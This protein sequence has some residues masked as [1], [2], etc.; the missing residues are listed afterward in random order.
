MKTLQDRMIELDT[1]KNEIAQRILNEIMA[2][3]ESMP[4]YAEKIGYS[5]LG[6]AI[7]KNV[8][9]NAALLAGILEYSDIDQLL[10][11]IYPLT[12]K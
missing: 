2:G 12:Q 4:K 1:N 6:I 8:T 9:S 3:L 10:E 7:F 5:A 11:D